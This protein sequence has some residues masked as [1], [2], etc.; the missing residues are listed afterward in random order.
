MV[1]NSVVP[2][3]NPPIASAKIA[4][5]TC[6]QDAVGSTSTRS[7]SWTIAASVTDQCSQP[8]TDTRNRSHERDLILSLIHISEP[9]RQAEISYA[10]FCL[11]KKKKKNKK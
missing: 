10:V 6:R 7:A 5:L 2:M 3:A 8:R 4:R 11:K 1:T 9:T